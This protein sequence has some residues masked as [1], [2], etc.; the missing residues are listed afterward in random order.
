MPPPLPLVAWLFWIV[1][2]FWMVRSLLPPATLIPPPLCA[3]LAKVPD[4]PPIVLLSIVKVSA[5]VKATLTPPPEPFEAS[6]PAMV[7]SVI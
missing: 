7:L 3:R 4:V 1:V 2:A 6:L 5:N